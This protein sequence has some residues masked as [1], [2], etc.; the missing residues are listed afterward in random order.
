MLKKQTL[1][2]TASTEKEKKRKVFNA[3]G[4]KKIDQYPVLR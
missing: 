3:S 1:Y 2:N 4:N